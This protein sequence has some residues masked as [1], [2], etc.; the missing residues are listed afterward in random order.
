MSV[1][2]LAIA[3]HH[4]RAKGSAKLVLIG[5]ANHQGDGG[6]WPS[7]YT[8]GKYAH[9]DRRNVQRALGELE[10]LGEIRRVLSQGGD[11]ST[12]DHLRPNLYRFLLTCPADCDR[13][14]N[15]RTRRDLAVL[16]ELP[17]L[18]LEGA[19]AAPRGQGGLG[20]GGSAAG[21]AALASG[22]G[23]AAAPP[24]PLRQPIDIEVN[25]VL[26]VA[27]ETEEESPNDR[28]QRLIDAEPR[29]CPRRRPGQKHVYEASGY[30]GP[31]GALDPQKR[32]A[33]A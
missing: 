8:L 28:Y 25:K 4:S 9:V 12:A 27:R 21:G 24:K 23:A 32:Q 18:E 17:G 3:L 20:G 14:S 26:V 19:A 16:P 2:A 30:C 29:Q 1:E 5:I 31:C 11:H 7:V 13:S 33:S 10:K 15:H 22:E 6:A